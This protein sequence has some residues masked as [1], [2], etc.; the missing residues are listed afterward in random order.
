MLASFIVK[1]NFNTISGGS[2]Y[3]QWPFLMVPVPDPQPGSPE[4]LYNELH[5]T[6]YN[7]AQKTVDMLKS[8]F[9]CLLAQYPLRYEPVMVAKIVIACCVLHNI[10]NRAGLPAP[11]LEPE[12]QQHET[13]FRT[14]AQSVLQNSLD[15]SDSDNDDADDSQSHALSRRRELINKL[16]H[17]AH[18]IA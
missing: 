3:R 16:W 6:A 10:C 12:E 2:E 14:E 18:S 5:A 13:H 4:E 15:E 11:T 1:I 9:R 8:R 7:S 17:N